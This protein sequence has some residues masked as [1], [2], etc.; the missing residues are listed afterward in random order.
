MKYLNRLV[1]VMFG[2]A[3]LLIIFVLPYAIFVA[4]PELNRVKAD[5]I[6]SGGYPYKPWRTQMICIKKEAIIP[7]KDYT[8]E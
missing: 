2:F 1:C 8:N 7:R 3:A 5:C 4:L 6:A